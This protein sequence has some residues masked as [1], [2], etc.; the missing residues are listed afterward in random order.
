MKRYFFFGD[1][2][3]FGEGDIIEGGW[4]KRLEIKWNNP[5]LKLINKGANGEHLMLL[6]KRFLQELSEITGKSQDHII[7][8]Y[9]TNDL[10]KFNGNYLVSIKRFEAVYREIITLA[11]QK[12]NLVSICTILPVSDAS[13]GVKTWYG[14]T[15]RH[16]NILKY[17]T[18]IRSLA[19]EFQ[20]NLIDWYVDFSLLKD[21]FLSEDGLHP[22]PTGYQWLCDFAGDKISIS[23]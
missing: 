14:F 11:L 13:E 19:G 22:N 7:F 16:E 2:I 3:T 23:G 15:R 21:E 17:N 8:S 12:T 20:L 10:A 1:S 6:Q 9:G 4:V 5:E 18:V